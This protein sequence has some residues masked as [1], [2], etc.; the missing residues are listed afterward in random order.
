MR[1]VEGGPG[2]FSLDVELG[3]LADRVSP[4][5]LATGARLAT[6]V[7]FAEAREILG[8][9][10]P[11]PPSTEVLEKVVLGLGHHTQ[12]WFAQVAPPKDD[13]EVLVILIDGKCVPTAN[14]A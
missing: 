12:E 7:S 6:R 10:V 11:Q 8:W 4:S 5:L 2:W 1:P 14:T 9:F 13:G 3:L